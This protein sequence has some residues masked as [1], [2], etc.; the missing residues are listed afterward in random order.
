MFRSTLN[1]TLIQLNRNIN[2]QGIVSL[3]TIINPN[4]IPGL[5][6]INKVGVV[7]LGL[8]IYLTNEL[9]VL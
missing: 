4:T 2:R 1:R 6:S 3:S 7:G 8:I 5:E 9:C